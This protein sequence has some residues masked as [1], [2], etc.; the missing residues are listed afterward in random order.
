MK[1][2]AKTLAGAL[3]AV[4]LGAGLAAAQEIDRG[5][6][7][8]PP[9]SFSEEQAMLDERMRGVFREL[10]PALKND[11]MR[12]VND[13]QAALELKMRKNLNLAIES[14]GAGGNN[15]SKP[16]EGQKEN[17][18]SSAVP[19]GSV[20]ISCVNKKALYRDQDNTLF[21]LPAEAPES[22]GRCSG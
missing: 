21:Q 11:I 5:N 12:R 17:A 3:L 13:S 22:V 18:A 1:Y 20:F 4:H 10:E 2:C 14:M 8:L 6:P 16:G 19:Q 15:Q 9:P 7:F